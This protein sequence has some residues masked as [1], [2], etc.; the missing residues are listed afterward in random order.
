ML[1]E[2]RKLDRSI[3]VAAVSQWRRRLCFTVDISNTFCGFFMV[4]CVK[5][6]LRIYEFE[7]L[8]YDCFVCCQNVTCLKRFTRYGHYAGKV[9]DR[10]IARLAVIS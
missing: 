1:V 7:V 4:Q 3:V 8:L 10:I 6:M 2:W 5:L 9:E